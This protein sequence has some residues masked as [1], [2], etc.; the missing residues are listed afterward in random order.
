L[1]Q[2]KY[3]D[4]IYVLIGILWLSRRRKYSGTSSY[5]S[6]TFLLT[7]TSSTASLTSM[8]S[9]TP[10]EGE[11]TPLTLASRQALEQ[12]ATSP[13]PQCRSNGQQLSSNAKRQ[14]TPTRDA[15]A[16]V[17]WLHVGMNGQTVSGKNSSPDRNY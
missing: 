8:S 6:R 9:L 12:G 1:S 3:R 17:A 5:L 10:V 14:S 4:A 13:L 15:D 7:P 2:P 16:T 11:L